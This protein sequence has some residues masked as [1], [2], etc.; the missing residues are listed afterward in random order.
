MGVEVQASICVFWFPV[1]GDVQAAIILPL[2]QDVKKRDSSVFLHLYSEP[3]EQSHTV[4]V[5]QE[6][7]HCALLHDAA[8]V[9]SLFFQSQVF[10]G[11]VL[12]VYKSVTTAETGDPIA[13][14][15]C[16]SKNSL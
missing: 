8:G 3:D 14:P 16:C 13:A 10:V 4:Q 12:S 11:A 6:F 5:G 1:D 7:F 15:P 2:E 9:I